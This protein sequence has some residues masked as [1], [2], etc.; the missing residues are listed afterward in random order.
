MKILKILNLV[1]LFFLFNCNSEQESDKIPLTNPPL[2]PIYLGEPPSNAGTTLI[3]D[4]DGSIKFIFRK[5]DWDYGGFSD[6]VFYMTTYDEGRTWSEPDILGNTG[7]GSQ[8]FSTI[9]PISGEVTTFFIRR[10]PG[11]T[12]KVML[13]LTEKY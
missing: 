10:Q 11:V 12:G 6:T 13:A 7:K 3:K 8:C 9:S 2:E 4:N 1:I 5:G